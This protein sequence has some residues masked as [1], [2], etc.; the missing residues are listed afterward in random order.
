MVGAGG[1]DTS[2]P[3]FCGLDQLF[4]GELE[5]ARRRIRSARSALLTH[6]AA[7]DRRGR[8]ALEVMEELGASPAVIFTPE[9]GFDGVAQAEEPVA[10]EAAV[11][12]DRL[13]SEGETPVE[14]SPRPDSNWPP[15]F[16]SLYGSTRES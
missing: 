16:V 15:P 14:G 1:W 4:G 7:V 11:P 2:H 3:M 8:S 12:A 10:T 5:G 9:H 13:P 6:P